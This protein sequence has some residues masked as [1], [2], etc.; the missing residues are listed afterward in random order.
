MEPG[1]VERHKL[2][3]TRDD[4][5]LEAFE[6]LAEEYAARAPH[7]PHNALYD[8]PAMLSLLPCVAGRRVFDAGC[9]PGIYTEWLVQHGAETVACDLSPSMIRL[10][11]TRLRGRARLVVADLAAPLDFLESA[12]FDV[13]VS[14]LALDYVKDWLGVL[15]EF[16][17]ILRPGGELV[18]SVE[19]PGATFFEHHPGGNYFRVERIQSVWRGFGAPVVVPAY[20]RS[21]GAMINPLIEAGFGLEQVLE[22]RPVEE[23]K[24]H[25]VKEYHNLMRRP[26]F[27][28]FRAKR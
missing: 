24:R 1:S 12:S 28:C 14:A 11:E 5:V 17:R 23:F 25:D 7:K 2:E 26:G 20:R 19:H 3:G 13:I 18:F 4:S 15:R 21:L 8:R 6:V 10:A 27:I 16:H 22:P 9:G